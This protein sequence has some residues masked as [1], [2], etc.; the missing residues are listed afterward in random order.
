MGASWQEDWNRY[1]NEV[2]AVVYRWY[3]YFISKI[4][5]MDDVRMICFRL[6]CRRFFL[7]FQLGT[8]L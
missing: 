8:V 5:Q 3:V 2:A 4:I 6:L 7:S 1:V